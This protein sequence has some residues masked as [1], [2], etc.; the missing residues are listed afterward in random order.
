MKQS[1]RIWNKTMNKAILSWG[2]KRLAANPCVY[3][4]TTKSGTIVTVIHVDLSRHMRILQST[5]AHTLVYFRSGKCTFC[6]SIVFTRNRNDRTISLSQT[7]LI[8]KVLTTFDRSNA[9]PISTPMDHNSQLRRRPP[10]PVRSASEL[11]LKGLPYRSLVRSLMYLAGGTRPD[12]SY[13][14][15][16]LTQFLGCY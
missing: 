4:R 6:V 3:Y 7:A 15:L 5:I 13:T 16:K 11:A 12:I 10:S 1:G 14:V 2:L 8:N 9:Y